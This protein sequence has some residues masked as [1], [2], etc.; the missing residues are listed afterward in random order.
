MLPIAIGLSHERSVIV[1]GEMCPHFDGA[2]LHPVIATWTVVHQFEIVGR[3]LLEP[4]LEPHEEG[5][6]IHVSVDHDSPAWVGATVV[7]RAVAESCDGRRL[8]TRMTARVGEREIASGRF[9]QAIVR[10]EK[11]AEILERH[12]R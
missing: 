11:L 1:T 5:I 10:K 12:R 4:H 3:K 7:F 2:M 8:T 6:G 9:V